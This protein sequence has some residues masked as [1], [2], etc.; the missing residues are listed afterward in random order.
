MAIKIN[1][2]DLQK[3]YIGW[4]EVVKV[5][6]NGGEIRPNT[7]PPTPSFTINADLTQWAIPSWWSSDWWT[8]IFWPNWFTSPNYARIKTS[9]PSFLDSNKIR[10]E[11]NFYFDWTQSSSMTSA[12]CSLR[13]SGRER[14]ANSCSFQ[15]LWG[16]A[17]NT[18]FYG[19]ASIP[20]NSSERGAYPL[21]YYKLVMN[22][23]LSLGTVSLTLSGAFYEHIE[24]TI[25]SEG[26]DYIKTINELEIQVWNYVTI[27]NVKLEVRNE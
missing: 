21:W 12:Y 6:L 20:L 9:V 2:Q 23:D 19:W 4:Q 11:M 26:I 5:M 14:I 7:V 15:Y 1:W 16:R 17:V 25:S 22:V 10:T 3:R 8:P 13:E 27:S 24:W 18:I